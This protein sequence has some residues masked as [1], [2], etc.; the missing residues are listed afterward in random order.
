MTEHFNS[1]KRIGQL[2]AMLDAVVC[3]VITIRANG[4]I[5]SANPFTLQMFG[6]TEEELLNRNVKI[7]MPPT[8]GTQHDD[9][10][11][12]YMKTGHRRIIGI[13]RDVTAR[14][15]NGSDFPI[16]LA[17]GEYSF[18]GETFFVGIM[19]DLSR[20]KQAET[21]LV[22]AQRNEALGQLSG[23]TAHDF[24][25]ILTI[26]IGN[27][28]LLQLRSLDKDSHHLLEEALGAAE[29]G[30]HLASRLLTFARQTELQPR[31]INLNDTINLIA[32]MT[33]RTLGSSVA[34]STQLQ[35]G[36]WLCKVDPSQLESALLNLAL[37]SR[38]AMPEGG[39]LIIETRNIEV[40]AN[41]VAGK[42]EL[43]PGQYVAIAVSDT[44]H[45]M[46]EAQRQRACDPFF[47]TKPIGKGTGLGLSVLSGFVEQSGGQVSIY[48]EPR[49][50]T[51]V[52]I[53]LPRAEGDCTEA[54][55]TVDLEPSQ[56]SSDN[57]Q[58]VV[59]LNSTLV[60]VVED[61]A[62]ILRLTAE[63]LRLLGYRTLLAENAAEAIELLDTESDIALVFTDVVMPGEMTG[64]DLARYV[65]SSFPGIAVLLTSGF[66][67]D[68]IH[69]EKLKELDVGLLRKPYRLDRLKTAVLEALSARRP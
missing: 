30:S 20:Q 18:E 39:R 23:G 53:Y 57:E 12:R 61:E 68:I 49:L 63:R 58:S 24:N 54:V 6:Y 36:I 60:L 1:W 55:Q 10:L 2:E 45:G 19:K 15:K 48:S 52:T 25:N 7:L 51:T 14:H 3:A 17:V 47:T 37:N 59:E 41:Y 27:L 38:D 42:S 9:F 5:E 32:S 31:L 16:H 33:S 44:G 67:E 29:S 13:G 65:N 46:E 28:E 50:G 64:Y 21:R 56:S 11:D 66:A 34:F 62:Q 43:V 8:V 35:D 69:P 26:I 40:D 4:D 22:W